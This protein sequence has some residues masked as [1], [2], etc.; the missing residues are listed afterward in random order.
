M[1]K[2]NEKIIS[3]TPDTL[4]QRLIKFTTLL[5]PNATSWSFILITLIYNALSVALQHAIRLD[6]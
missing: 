2:V 6:G 1:S 5:P 3:L 4:G